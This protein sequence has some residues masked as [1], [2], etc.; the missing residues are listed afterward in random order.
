[1]QAKLETGVILMRH[2]SFFLT[3]FQTTYSCDSNIQPL[4]DFVSIEDDDGSLKS[5]SGQLWAQ[6][7]AD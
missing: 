4:N 1:M 5:R 3:N 7:L 2:S 6:G